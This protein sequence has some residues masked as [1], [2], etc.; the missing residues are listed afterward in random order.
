MVHDGVELRVIQMM[1][2]GQLMFQPA[3]AWKRE[4]GDNAQIKNR[5]FW[6]AVS[7]EQSPFTV[8]YPPFPVQTRLARWI[9]SIGARTLP[10][11]KREG[12]SEPFLADS[13]AIRL[14]PR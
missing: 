10:D 7:L 6:P 5:R 3:T 9:Y 12:E 4:F 2:T 11:V 1:R 14:T 8:T 13:A